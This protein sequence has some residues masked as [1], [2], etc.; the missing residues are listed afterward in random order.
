MVANR[1][2][3]TAVT[4]FGDPS[5]TAGQTFDVGTAT[6]DGVSCGVAGRETS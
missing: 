1:R 2:A 5:F 6:T 4:V 3:V